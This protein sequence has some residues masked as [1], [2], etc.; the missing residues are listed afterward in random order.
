MHLQPANLRII[1][2]LHAHQL[3]TNYGAQTSQK[4]SPIEEVEGE[5]TYAD[6]SSAYFHKGA[7]EGG[8]FEGFKILTST[9]EVENL[10]NILV[11]Q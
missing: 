10:K 6:G 7:T 2:G 1:I 8:N 9:V 5:D 3:F 11:L 4:N